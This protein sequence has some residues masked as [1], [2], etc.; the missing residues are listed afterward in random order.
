MVFHTRTPTDV[1]EGP[2]LQPFTRATISPCVAGERTR[3]STDGTVARYTLL[4]PDPLG[5]YGLPAT[6]LPPAIHLISVRLRT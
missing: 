2:C 4:C 1:R 6:H 3:L 5:L